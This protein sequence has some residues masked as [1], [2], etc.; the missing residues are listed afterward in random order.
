MKRP[1]TPW[2]TSGNTS[3][4]FSPLA[5]TIHFPFPVGSRGDWGIDLTDTSSLSDWNPSSERSN[6]PAALVAWERRQARHPDEGRPSSSGEADAGTARG[7]HL[8]GRVA[9]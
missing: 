6:E 4:A 9:S 5:P 8:A 2:T 1:R 7:P 3:A